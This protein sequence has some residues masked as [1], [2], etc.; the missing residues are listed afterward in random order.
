M[1]DLMTQRCPVT[2]KFQYSS[3]SDAMK[4]RDLA[5]KYGVAGPAQGPFHQF[6]CVFCG[7][8]HWGHHRRRRQF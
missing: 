3:R 5:I 7:A 6:C 2:G 8:W 4:G 1:P